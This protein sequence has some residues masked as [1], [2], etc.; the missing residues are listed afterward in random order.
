[1]AKKIRRKIKQTKIKI[2]AK[3][4]IITILH[5]T[6]QTVQ[7][8]RKKLKKNSRKRNTKHHSKQLKNNNA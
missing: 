2:R 6:Q 7:F 5:I 8:D 3:Y 4:I 1:M